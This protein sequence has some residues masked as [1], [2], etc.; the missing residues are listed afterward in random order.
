[1]QE[2]YFW[3]GTAVVDSINVVRKSVSRL[4]QIATDLQAF[5]RD[6]RGVEILFN[7]VAVKQEP[8]PE[9]R[10][11]DE[12][13]L[14][15]IAGQMKRMMLAYMFEHRIDFWGTEL[16]Y[17]NNTRVDFRE[18]H[19][20]I[21]GAEELCKLPYVFLWRELKKDDERGLLS[22]EEYDQYYTEATD[23]I[24]GC[25]RWTMIYS[26]FGWAGVFFFH[27]ISYTAAKNNRYNEWDIYLGILEE[28]VQWLTSKVRG[29]LGP[30]AKSLFEVKE[31]PDLDDLIKILDQM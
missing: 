8:L 25:T 16:F 20:Y 7:M 1:M 28:E 14:I 12:N 21:Y 29:K 23:V 26:R 3:W 27:W 5:Q 4:R 22:K 10:R 6:E 17:F 31:P 11:N 13:I 30:S 19:R 24:R 9:K 18:Q 15:S 2:P